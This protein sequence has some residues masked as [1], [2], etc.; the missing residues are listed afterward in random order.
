MDEP[1]IRLQGIGKTY[2]SQIS[3]TGRLGVLWSLLNGREAGLGSPSLSDITFDVLRGQSLGLIGENGA[4]KSTLLKIIAGVVRPTSGT[5]AVTGKI[6]ALLELGAGF[7]PEYTGRENIHL[8]ASLMGLD[9]ATVRDRLDEI[10]AFAD[11]GSHLDQPVKHYSSG[12]VVRLGFA[13]ATS[14]RPDVLITDEVLAVGDESFQRKCTSWMERYLGDGGTLLL[15]SHGMFH[16]QKLCRSAAWIHNG[17][18]R[19]LGIAADVTRE[20]LAY[21]EEKSRAT[22]QAAGAPPTASSHHTYQVQSMY[23]NGIPAQ[24]GPHTMPCGAT[25][26]LSGTI[27]S[28]D[29]RIPQV[30]VGLV[31]ADG[32]GIY[33]VTSD[34]EGISLTPVAGKDFAFAVR[35]P[36]LP[37]LPGRYLIR[38]HAMD[39]EGMR[40]LDQV[41]TVLDVVGDSRELG[42]CHIKHEWFDPKLSTPETPYA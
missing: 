5:V 9:R 33:G 14:V 7:H 31:R 17:R 28:P 15:C 30:A 39:P 19:S 41:E 42:V 37:L 8:A 1:L 24:D 29:G 13:V 27:F 18:L 34:M 22:Q 20:Y 16:I 4:G 36:E 38:S 32:S 11:I 35:F 2:P 40:M 21:H 12:M 26:T 6:S 23:L 10:V 3:S 25:L